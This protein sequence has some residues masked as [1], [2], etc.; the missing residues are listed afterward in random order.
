MWGVRLFFCFY[1]CFLGEANCFYFISGSPL[2]LDKTK[3][4]E[5]NKVTNQF[6]DV[7]KNLSSRT[8]KTFAVFVWYLDYQ[9]RLMVKNF[10]WFQT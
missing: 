6:D 10:I 7:F 1:S 5:V 3:K 4:L 9:V 8:T 2:L